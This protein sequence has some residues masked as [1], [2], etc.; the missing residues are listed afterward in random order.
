MNQ[1]PLAD[2]PTKLSYEDLEKKISLLTSRY[3]TAR[4]MNMNESIL[5]QLDLM[6]Q[7]LEGEKQRRAMVPD[8]GKKVL[9]DTDD[10][11]QT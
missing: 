4:R 9:I 7:G 11:A 1:H 10:Q 5:H 2:D 6:L 3:Y 8:D